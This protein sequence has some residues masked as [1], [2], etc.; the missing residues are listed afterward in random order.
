ML[1]KLQLRTKKE[2]KRWS[3]WTFLRGHDAVP[4]WDRKAVDSLVR[5]CEG[6]ATNKTEVKWRLVD[7][8]TGEEVP[9]WRGRS[10]T[11]DFEAWARSRNIIP[12][13]I[14][15]RQNQM[16]DVESLLERFDL[17]VRPTD[18]HLHEYC[19]LFYWCKSPK[20]QL[21]LGCYNSFLSCLYSMGKIPHQDWSQHIK[22]W[23][24]IVD[25]PQS[26]LFDR[27]DAANIC[28][29]LA[30]QGFAIT[31][32][33]AKLTPNELEDFREQTGLTGD[34]SPTTLPDECKTC[35]KLQD[36][37]NCDKHCIE[38][39]PP[40]QPQSTSTSPKQEDSLF[41]S[42]S[43]SKND[44]FGLYTPSATEPNNPPL[45]YGPL[46]VYYW[47]QAQGY[48]ALGLPPLPE[49]REVSAEKIVEEFYTA[50]LNRPAQG[51]QYLPNQL[52]QLAAQKLQVHQVYFI[53]APKR[54]RAVATF[55]NFGGLEPPVSGVR[56]DLQNTFPENQ[57]AQL[58][59][60]VERHGGSLNAREPLT[61]KWFIFIPH[62]S[63]KT[64]ARELE[65]H[66]IEIVKPK[67]ELPTDPQALI[68]MVTEAI[69]E[70]IK[71]ESKVTLPQT[72]RIGKKKKKKKKKKLTKKVSP[73]QEDPGPKFMQWA[74]E[75]MS[76]GPVPA[77][78]MMDELRKHID[79]RGQRLYHV[80]T[81][82]KKRLKAISVSIDGKF[83]WSLSE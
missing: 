32:D 56:L 42:H 30:L 54:G 17:E 62:S 39:P 4:V 81:L 55:T 82:I 47:A 18:D 12:T 50:K 10:V 24:F 29:Y 19:S 65:A 61:D 8:K 13:L 49:D 69:N 25:D 64:A 35:R 34:P 74:A 43:P 5:Q 15:L 7:C 11:D 16:V 48:I 9:N 73:S 70:A 68:S 33:E 41:G 59:R 45:V 27:A 71:R 63:Y 83:H 28:A 31:P 21:F 6:R 58:C 76:Q 72:I 14:K 57:W 20:A 26:T 75:K 79:V 78:I 80:A 67:N 46:D 66:G 37:P 53:A 51:P 2:G 23:N 1:V 52:E 22:N 40:A 60:T 77:N 3:N 44:G 36:Y 38:T